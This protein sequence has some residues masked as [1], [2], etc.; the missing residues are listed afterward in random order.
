VLIGACAG[1]LTLSAQ[2]LITPKAAAAENSAQIEAYHAIV[3]QYATGNVSQAIGELTR[4]ATAETE[5]VQRLVNWDPPLMRAAAMLETDAAFDLRTS[6][7]SLPFR[8][9]CADTWLEKA[10]LAEPRNAP[11][12]LRRRWHQVVGR[13]LVANGLVS[14]AD[15]TLTTGVRLYPDDFDLLLTFATAKESLAL[16]VS[17]DLAA[18]QPSTR[19][20]LRS[21]DI[22]LSSARTALERIV[23]RVPSSAEAKLRLAHIHVVDHE[24]GRATPLLEAARSLKPPPPIDYLASIMLGEILAQRNQ[25]DAALKLFAHALELMPNAQSAYLAQAHALRSAGRLDDAA[26][27]LRTMLARAEHAPDPWKQYSL[28]FDFDLSKLNAL[29]REMRGQ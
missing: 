9:D 11:K 24:P 4:H 8:L 27:V 28:G 23:S 22:A 18:I 16:S 12:T 14:V 15:R 7:S 25:L 6:I 3:V 26:K 17:A 1:A 29:R 20:L 21:R 10:D 5:R 13:V 2:T 19:A